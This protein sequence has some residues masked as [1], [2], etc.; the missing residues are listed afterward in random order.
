M[1]ALLGAAERDI[2]RR[3]PPGDARYEGASS[4]GLLGTVVQLLCSR[5]LCASSVDVTIVAEATRLSPHIKSTRETLATVLCLEPARVSIT[6]T[7]T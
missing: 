2:G 3:F 7:T 5:R 4:L 1:D 6:V